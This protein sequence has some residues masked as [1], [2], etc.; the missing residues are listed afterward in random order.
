MEPKGLLLAALVVGLLVLAL[1]IDQA[2]S[3]TLKRPDENG[4]AH[5]RGSSVKKT[6]H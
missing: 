3:D 4:I 1:S 5:K 6:G 2:I